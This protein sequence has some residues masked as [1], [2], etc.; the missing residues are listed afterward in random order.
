MKW[1]IGVLG[2]AGSLAGGTG[3]RSTCK[4]DQC[5]FHLAPSSI[6]RRSVSISPAESRLPASLGGI[7]SSSSVVVMRAISLLWSLWPGTIAWPSDSSAA[8]AA[9]S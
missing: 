9:F 1:S 5:P 4:Y 3:G 7:T 6:Q 2:Q 8:S